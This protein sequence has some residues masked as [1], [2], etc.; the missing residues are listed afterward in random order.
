[1]EAEIP[2]PS[3]QRLDHYLTA[4]YP[5]IS[6]AYLQKLCNT[7]QVLVNGAP[8]KSGFRIHSTDAVVV[9]Y[10]LSQIE[11]TPDITLPILYE[12][13]DVLVINKPAGII[14]HARGKYYNEAS[15]ASFI[16]SYFRDPSG[17][18][19]GIVHRLDRATSGVM[20]C[21]KHAAAM[22]WLQEQFANRAVEKVY[23]AVVSGHMEPSE[24]VI[25]MPIERNPKL[26]ST[27]RVG[28]NGK[29]ST[30]LYK[31]VRLYDQHE[32]LELRPKTGRTH[33][34]RVHLKQLDHTIVG[35]TLY[36]GE[37]ADRLYLH[38]HQLILTLPNHKKATF[39]ADL[40]NEFLAFKD[41]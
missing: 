8:Q 26:P 38:A 12:D 21:A 40:P 39:T 41:T 36:G 2:Y 5:D 14:S 13:N 19:A 32:L 15:V 29:P 34:L 31:V 4:L 10:D 24:A 1:M 33:Q 9:L 35:D 17:Q 20:I 37:R 16:R 30:T 11:K 25:D 28:S 3:R 22:A 7:D 23:V 6:R 27:F 18:R